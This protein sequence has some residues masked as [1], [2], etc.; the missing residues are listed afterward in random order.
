MGLGERC[1]EIVRMIDE[2]LAGLGVDPDEVSAVAPAPVAAPATLAT[3]VPGP[4]LAA[5]GF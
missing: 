4:D 2:T 3:P 5:A 1:D